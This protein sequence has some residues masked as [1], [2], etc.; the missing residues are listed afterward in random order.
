MY[1]IIVVGSGPAGLSASIYGMRAGKKTLVIEKEYEGTGQIALSSQVDNYLGFYNI[2]GYELGEHFREHAL[3][4]GVEIKNGTVL[5]IEKQEDGFQIVVKVRKKEEIFKSKN[6]IYCA[7][8]SH[9]L[10]GV[11]GEKR[12]QGKGVSYCAICDGN[13]FKNKSVAVVGGGDT[14]LDDALYLSD[15]AE[16][17]T[18][19]HRRNEFR[20][21][22]TT[23]EKLRNKENVKIITGVNILSIEGEN[24]VESLILDNG[25]TIETNG[26]FIAVGMIPETSLLGDLVAY[27]SFGY[28]DAAED[29]RTSCKGIYV[30]GDV[31][32]KNL[33]QVVTAVADGANAVQSILQDM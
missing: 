2:G 18:L 29:C 19:L 31:R 10:L 23:L 27:D 16:Q 28:V 22:Y 8:A 32:S 12:L 6:I 30:A 7:G 15:I 1:E 25:T 4:L 33:R 3:N 21:S 13:F 24:Q 11:E 14:A 20:G 5:S 17:V 9:R 26:V